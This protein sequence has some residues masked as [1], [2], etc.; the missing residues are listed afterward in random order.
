MKA[1]C[2]EVTQP[3]CGN[4]GLMG[5]WAEEGKREGGG[6][7]GGGGG[8]GGPQPSEQE[9]MAKKNMGL[10]VSLGVQF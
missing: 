8:G 6:G 2:G 9:Q 5:D 4:R 3:G 1:F 7:W 10:F